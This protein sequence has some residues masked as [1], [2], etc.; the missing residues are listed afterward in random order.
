MKLLVLLALVSVCSANLIWPDPPKSNLDVV[1]EAFWDYV[2]K[3]TQT[4]EDSLQQIRQSDLGQELNTRISQSTDTVNQYYASLHAQAAPVA[5][6][7]ISRITQEAEQL[8]VRLDKDLS[9]MGQ[10]LQP[11]AEELVAQL[12]T[13]VEELKREVS[14]LAEAMDPEALRAVLLQKSQELKGQLEKSLSQLQAQATPY[15]EEM[16][17]KME[18]SLEDFQKNLVPLTQSFEIQL[19][20]KAQ[21]IQ[22]RLLQSGEELRAKLDSGAQDLQAQLTALWES[23]TQK[24]Q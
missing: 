17:E 2:A 4:A 6:D 1:K 21:E 8:K 13:R 7:V 23:F 11:Q 14:P 16:R 24:T 9:T 19:N 18:L 15:T 12:Q 5:Q 3:A 10:K 20:Q 22:Q